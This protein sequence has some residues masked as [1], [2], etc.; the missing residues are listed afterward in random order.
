M[1]TLEQTIKFRKKLSFNF[2]FKGSDQCV[3]TVRERLLK[4]KFVLRR[5]K[6]KGNVYRPTRGYRAA[7]MAQAGTNFTYL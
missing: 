1:H 2:L 7:T 5:E 4:I 6:E 3:V